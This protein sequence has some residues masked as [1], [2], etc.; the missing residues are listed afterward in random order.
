[1]LLLNLS[2]FSRQLGR[3]LNPA[4]DRLVEEDR[5][6]LPSLI[7]ET[8]TVQVNIP[9]RHPMFT[10]DANVH[11]SHTENYRGSPIKMCIHSYL[12]PDSEHLTLRKLLMTLSAEEYDDE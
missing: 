4:S 5:A 12:T 9:D 7:G 3:L 1:M 11:H 6:A 10:G 2:D 8:S